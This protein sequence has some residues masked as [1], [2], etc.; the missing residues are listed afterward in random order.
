MELYLF[1]RRGYQIPNYSDYLKKA[2]ESAIAI[3]RQIE[4]TGEYKNM[5][6]EKADWQNVNRFT[7]AIM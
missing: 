1:Y 3:K 5:G 4:V 6:L 2:E 7:T